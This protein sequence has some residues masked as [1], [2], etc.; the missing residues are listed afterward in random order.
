MKNQTRLFAVFALLLT[1]LFSFQAAYAQGTEETELTETTLTIP[2]NGEAEIA[3]QGYCL[4]FGEPFP[5]AFGQPSRRA[6]DDILRVL[7]TALQ[8][9]TATDDPLTITLAIWSLRENQ[10]ITEL[11][12]NLDPSVAGDVDDLLVRSEDASVAPLATDLGIALDQAVA[13]GQVEVTSADFAADTSAPAPIAT[14]EGEP[15]HGE[16]TMTIRNLTDEEITIYYAFG[17]ILVAQDESE[18]DLVTYSTELETVML[19][20]TPA[21][22]A[23]A[24]A[25]ATVAATATAEATATV[26][27]TATAEATATA[28]PTA[29]AQ[30]PQTMPQT[31]AAPM[32]SGAAPTL[33]IAGLGLIGAAYLVKR[34]R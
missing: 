15:Y 18:Q 26:A 1:A 2:A 11:Y 8:E 28:Q 34:R 4:D 14:E 10:P 24:P 31:G 12:P 33:I 23:T 16:G 7:K 17:T 30:A 32:T 9:G 27:A 6:D 20:P 21:A 13:D 19:Q 29:T 25:T 22:S 5:T 3:F